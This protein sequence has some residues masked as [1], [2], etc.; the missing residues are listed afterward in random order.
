MG[1]FRVGIDNYSLFPLKLNPLE[2]L[3][4][5][6][7]HA[8]EGVA[9]S[10]FIEPEYQQLPSAYLDDLKQFAQA[11]GLYLEWGGA[12]HIPRDMTLWDK[13][14]LFKINQ[15]A[16]SEAEKL[17]TR[18]VRSCSGGLMRWQQ[19]SPMTETLLQETAETLR[20]QRSMLQD[21]NVIL[22][23]ETHFE[24]TTFELLKIFERCEAEPGEFVG[25][26][27]DTMN[28]LT[29]LEDPVMAT[30][31]MLP[32]VVSTHIKDG[33]LT[34]NSDG[35][36]SFVAELGRGVIDFEK[37]FNR[38]KTLDRDLNLNVEDHGGDFSL[39]IYDPLFLSK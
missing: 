10:G 30:E 11:N 3:H 14:D 37:I 8:A 21:H 17:D 23:I 15:K 26:C 32:W 1:Q 18:I 5:A 39:P 20:D 13:K 29:M 25:I 24:F 2:T 38:L 34:V 28:L 9:F 7:D 33:G 6:K 4:W 12:S 27:L 35:M 31:R 22:A 16:A 36:N 19:E